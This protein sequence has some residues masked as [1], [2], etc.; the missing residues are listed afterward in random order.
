LSKRNWVIGISIGFVLITIALIS[1]YVTHVFAG[2]AYGIIQAIIFIGC[3]VWVI[4]I[5]NKGE[6]I[7]TDGMQKEDPTTETGVIEAENFFREKY[8]FDQFEDGLDTAEEVTMHGADN[9]NR[10]AIFFW[11]KKVK[12]KNVYCNYI[13]PLFKIKQRTTFLGGN[14]KEIRKIIEEH[15][16]NPAQMREQITRSLTNEFGQKEFE[17]VNRYPNSVPTPQQVQQIEKAKDADIGGEA[18]THVK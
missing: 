7:S 5:L 10:T 11:R 14:I 12:G 8:L 1:L 4:I 15:A 18:P 17:T 13:A 16:D 2:L 6:S 3:L 9:S